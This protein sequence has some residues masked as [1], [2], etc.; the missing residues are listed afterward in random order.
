MNGK[1]IYEYIW[2]DYKK[3]EKDTNIFLDK[4]KKVTELRGFLYHFQSISDLSM[5]TDDENECYQ[6]NGGDHIPDEAFEKIRF[7]I[8]EV[9]ATAEKELNELAASLKLPDSVM[10]EKIIVE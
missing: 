6:I 4:G 3:M 7:V 9:L 2:D 10:K 8:E 1:D 5:V